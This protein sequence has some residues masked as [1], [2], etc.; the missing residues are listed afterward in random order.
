MSIEVTSRFPQISA[1]T[2]EHPADRA[3]TAA[4]RSIPLLDRVIKLLSQLGLERRQ[5]QVLLGN[6]VRLGS[7]QMVGVWEL[8]VATATTLDIPT[9]DL[10]ITQ[11]PLV[12]AMAIGSKRPVILL[13]SELVASYDDQEVH[14]VLAHEQGH[15]LSEHSYYTSAMYL[16][17][18]VLQ[19]FMPP[20]LLAGLPIRALYLALLEWHRATELSCD[21]ASAIV[22]GDPLAA[23]RMLMR[24]A[25]GPLPGLNLDAFLRQATQY[26]DEED[27]F[28]RHARLGEI[29]RTHPIAVRR[30]KELT[31][32]VGTG[33][34]DRILAGSYVHRGEE[35]PTSDEFNAAVAHY[36]ERFMGMVDRTVG[37]MA[38]LTGQIRQWLHEHGPEASREAE[39]AGSEDDL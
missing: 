9:P 6:A 39:D 31:S 37:G 2:Y 12:N 22:L 3:A 34:L 25:G 30:V 10:Y 32:W 23:C 26:V 36:R 7:D 35:P 33:A 20:G 11:T 28:A 16:L 38:K 8:Q 17:A 24:L 21:R 1:K 15:V 27:L 19:G 18:A 4:L 13:Y 14:A 29:Y 5:R